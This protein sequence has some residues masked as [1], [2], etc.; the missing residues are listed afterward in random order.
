MPSYDY[1]CEKCGTFEVRQGMSDAPLAACPTCGGK[2]DKLISR[3][4][5][6]LM[7]GGG[8]SYSDSGSAPSSCPTGTCPFVN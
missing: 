5:N 1:R 8:S 4:V 7:K 6:I 2:V 3:N